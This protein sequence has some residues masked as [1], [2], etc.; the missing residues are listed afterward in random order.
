[1]VAERDHFRKRRGGSICIAPP[2]MAI[3][4]VES[5]RH[6][7]GE[8]IRVSLNFCDVVNSLRLNDF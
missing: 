2:T 7:R 3:R 4:T 6:V 1:M 5:S 8:I